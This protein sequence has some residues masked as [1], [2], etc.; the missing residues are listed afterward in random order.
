MAASDGSLAALLNDVFARHKLEGAVVPRTSNTI[1]DAV[2]TG[3]PRFV[4]SHSSTQAL[5]DPEVNSYCQNRALEA[6]AGSPG[7]STRR[8]RRA[9]SGRLTSE[10]AWLRGTPTMPAR[11]TSRQMSG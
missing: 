5:Q 1:L 2:C 8:V 6:G 10:H 3:R 11:A 7:T 9:V 4:T